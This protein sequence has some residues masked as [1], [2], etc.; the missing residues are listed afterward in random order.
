MSLITFDFKGI[1]NLLAKNLYS[2]KKVFIRE[3]VQNAHD[4]I[5]RRQDC[6]KGSGGRIDIYCHPEIDQIIFQDSGIG[7]NQ[8]DLENYLASVGASGTRDSQIDGLIG[9]FGIGFLS[10]F[11][12]AKKVAVR[13]R[14]WGEANGWLWCNEGDQSYTLVPCDVAEVGTTVE[15]TLEEIGDRGLIRDEFVKDV[16]RQ[17]CDLLLVPIHVGSSEG[18]INT[19][20]MPWERDGIIG[21]ERALDCHAYLEK[22]M[23]DSVLETIP[24]D[25]RQDGLQAH[26]V[27]YISAARMVMIEAPRTVRV[28]LK[29]MF[30]CEN[31]IDLLP[32]WASFVNGVIDTPSLIPTAARDNFQRDELFGRLRDAL[33][34]VIIRHLEALKSSDPDRLSKILAYHDLSIKAACDYY[35]DFF[36]KFAHLL[37]WRVNSGDKTA[38]GF[39]G[40]LPYRRL[41]L[42]EILALLPAKTS[43]GDAPKRL[44]AF[45]T[46]S[47]ANQYFDM[48]NANAALVVDASWPW[49][50]KILTKLAGKPGSGFEVLFIDREEDPVIFRELSEH[51]GMV[52]RLAEVMSQVIMRQN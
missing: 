31:A 26:G 1:I 16:I 13:T 6:E 30:L 24:L 11:I 8:S 37:E 9:Q 47:S 33:G 45:S 50:A 52:R 7:M 25:L 44:S 49:D 19:M 21:K 3:L 35:T 22:T 29:R 48:A 32:K 41:P 2:E 43:D 17:Y 12:V 46:H 18:P 20:R 40:E 36:D 14:K 5:R 28:F 42:P 27:L 15:I 34:Q 4:A 39:S 38:R 10:A 23:R 51:D